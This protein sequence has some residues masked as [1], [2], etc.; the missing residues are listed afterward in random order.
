MVVSLGVTGM[1]AGWRGGEFI[2]PMLPAKAKDPQKQYQINQAIEI[3]T[4]EVACLGQG[5]ETRQ[6]PRKSAVEA[7]LA[8]SIRK[9]TGDALGASPLDKNS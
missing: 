5:L 4:R 7:S 2:N 8:H 9:L 3:I 6:Q 1:Q